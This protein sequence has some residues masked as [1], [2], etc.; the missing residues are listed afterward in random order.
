MS[1][2]SPASRESG[3]LP[4]AQEP[5]AV[6]DVSKGFWSKRGLIAVVVVALMASA[7][8]ALIPKYFGSRATVTRATHRV[9]RGD[10]TVILVDE[11]T[12]ESAKNTEIKCEIRGGY[13]GKGGSSGGG[14]GRITVNWVVPNG[15]MVKA[16]DELVRLDTKEVDETVSLGKTDTNLAKAE[17]SK[18]N[19]ALKNAE[20]AVTSYLEGQ[21]RSEL[22]NL[23]DQLAIAKSNLQAA[24]ETFAESESLFYG[25][26]IN[27]LALIAT[28]L[29]VEQANNDLTVAETNLDV[30]K[31]ITKAIE[32]ERRN[33][34][35]VATTARVKGRTAGLELEQG[36]LDLA[37]QEQKDCLV[38]AKR[39]GLVIYP[40]AA[41]W[42]RTPDIT[43]GATVRQDQVLL[44][45]PDLSKMRITI[46][47]HE[48]MVERV[49]AGLPVRVELPDQTVDTVISS[50][51]AVAR[52]AGWWT[53]NVV[54]YDAVIEIPEV[55]GLKPGMS[56]EVEVVIGR[57]TNVLMVPADAVL[58]T[59]NGNCCWV[60]TADGPQRRELE[61]GD[62]NLRESTEEF[63]VVKSGLQE[64]DQVI[65]EPMTSV[66]EAK[67]LIAAAEIYKVRRGDLPV[68]ITEQGTL[69]SSSNTEIKNKVR[70][71]STITWLIESG[72][73]VQPGDELVRLDNKALDEQVAE[74][75]KY[76]FLSK[77]AAVGS[78]VNAKT[79]KLA[80]PEYLEGRFIAE[81]EQKKKQHALAKSRL[82]TTQNF[83][84]YAAQMEKRG[85]E[86]KLE[87]A[88][89]EFDVVKAR[90][91]ME[92]MET[93]IDVFTRFEKMEEV[94]RL[95]GEFN[96]A[97]AQAQKDEEV[98]FLD[99]LWLKRI[100]EELTHCV[101]KADRSGLV[102][103][104]ATEEWKD[105]PDVTEGGVIHKNQVLLLMPDLSKMQVKVGIHESI[106]E[107]VT[108]GMLAR[109]KLPGKTLN[110][111]VSWVA[112]VTSPAGW[113]TGNI[114][115][116]DTLIELPQVEGLKPGMSAEVEILLVQ[117]ADVLT[118]PVA[119]V[120][121]TQ[122]GYCCWVKTTSGPQRREV[123]LG[124]GNNISLV[125]EAGLAEGDE[126]ILNPTASITE[127][128]AAELKLQSEMQK[129]LSPFAS[130]TGN[131]DM[132]VEGAP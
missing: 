71:K 61:L 114:V 127:A 84:V 122:Q 98:L 108:P 28:G 65:L 42:K 132:A 1:T 63:I 7:A 37:L 13:G 109:V 103:Y 59:G 10:L 94:A 81:L 29:T 105:A 26:S 115:K 34:A 120:V 44:L 90:L 12:L 112:P 78:A 75:T 104:P 2:D 64:G 27:D 3:S 32:E 102:I 124:D 85:Y 6:K 39:D 128:R 89:C 80:I 66:E 55:D 86:S 47:V 22:Q 11:G 96:M 110:G 100:R 4:R 14:W 8:F 101:V 111:K 93:Q 51:A 95:E 118:V 53:G 36:R 131:I 16:G 87:V 83:L 25:G 74:R 5:R 73:L 99:D 77:D 46:G 38:K 43:E 72:T 41:G 52:P 92:S 67:V 88:E 19:V 57:H 121:E 97:A 125:I 76:F 116:Y 15:S 119:A 21:Y 50:V 31:R 123:Q 18:A 58:D 117:H 126:V 30:F 130:D 91:A 79:A 69:E 82:L 45:M 17:L 60:E 70:G 107:R 9:A 113:W 48:S 106:V 33:G 49:H 20:I 23:K 129:V 68:S 62:S 35:V 24:E 54:E 40:S 56:A